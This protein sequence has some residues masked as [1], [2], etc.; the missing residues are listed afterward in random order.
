MSSRD[1]IFT[2]TR[3]RV[4]ISFYIQ[5]HFTE[6]YGVQSPRPELLWE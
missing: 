4:R 3:V 1:A 5:V 2:Q 6:S